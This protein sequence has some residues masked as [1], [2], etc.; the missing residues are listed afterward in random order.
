MYTSLSASGFGH[1]T[2]VITTHCSSQSNHRDVLVDTQSNIK[3]F[4]FIYAAAGTAR[5]LYR[6]PE[7]R[8]LPLSE[9]IKRERNV[10][11]AVIVFS[12]SKSSKNPLSE[13]HPPLGLVFANPC[14]TKMYAAMLLTVFFA[15]S[16][17]NCLCGIT[18]WSIYF[19][20][21]VEEIT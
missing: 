6:E 21:G 12:F 1:E 4:Q 20:F 19:T 18:E 2:P 8:V 11:G 14:E 3:E 16:F 13:V 7:E 17:Q 5:S 15:G 9:R 10:E